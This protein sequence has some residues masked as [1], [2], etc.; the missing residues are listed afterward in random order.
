[1]DTVPHKKLLEATHGVWIYQNLAMHRSTSGLLATQEKEQLIQEIE[2]QIEKGGNGLAEQD[3]WMLEIDLDRLDRSS[4]ER[5]SYWLL[6]IK[7]ARSHYSLSQEA[8]RTS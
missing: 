1:M 7:T 4:G 5:E 3:K 8:T 2:T 6:A